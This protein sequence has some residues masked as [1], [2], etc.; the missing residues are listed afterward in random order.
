MPI[1][2]MIIELGHGIHNL[3]SQTRYSRFHGTSG[4]FYDFV[5]M[6]SM[7]LENWY[8]TIRDFSFLFQYKTNPDS[9]TRSRWGNHFRTCIR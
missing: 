1:S 6:P 8:V 4:L 3:V 7:M 2:N 9:L 5:E